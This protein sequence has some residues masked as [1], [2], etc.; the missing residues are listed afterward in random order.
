MGLITKTVIIKWNA[1]NKQYF[2]SKN[3]IYTFLY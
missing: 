2:E 1:K 3:Y